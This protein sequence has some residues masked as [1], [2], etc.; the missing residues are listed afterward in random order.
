MT[1]TSARN[2]ALGGVTAALAVVLMCL[3]SLLVVATFVTPMLCMFLLQLVHARCGSKIGWAWYGAVAVLGLLL[4]PDREAAA[5]FTFLGYYPLVKPKL[6]GMRLRWVCKL[7]LFNAA[8]LLMY[9]VLIRLFGMDA[10]VSEFQK[11]GTAM[12]AAMLL[13]GNVIFI[14]IDRLLSRDF[15]RKLRGRR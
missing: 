3:G 1:G 9:T 11:L 5:V 15:L 8:T 6:D 10:I 12:T 7:L 14:L 4:V 13:T 2:I